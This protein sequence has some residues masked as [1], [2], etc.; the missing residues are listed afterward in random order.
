M[1]EEMSEPAM[2]RVLP[3]PEAPDV[4]KLTRLCEKYGIEIL[5]PLPV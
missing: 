1:I 5:G 3:A 2:E 4:D